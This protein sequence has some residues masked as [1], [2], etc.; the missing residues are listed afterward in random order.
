MDLY[1]VGA[2][3][4][5]ACGFVLLCAGICI[6]RY[7][8]EGRFSELRRMLSLDALCEVRPLK[9]MLSFLTSNKGSSIYRYCERVV[10]GSETGISIKVLL[11]LKMLSLLAAITLVLLIRYTN[12]EVMK[13][14]IIARSSEAFSF[15]P[16]SASEDYSYNLSLYNSVLKRVGAKALKEL[17][18]GERTDAVRKAMQELVQT[19]NPELLEER[20]RT[21]I[22]TYA[23]VNSFRLLDLQTVL[24]IMAAFW[25]PEI[26]LLLRRL[27]LGSRYKNELI[28]LENIFELLGS[29]Q[30]F[31][32]I[33]I[34]EEMTQASRLFRKHLEQ[35][36]RLFKTEKELAL[37]G[38]RQSIKNS[39]LASL[40]D[41]LR[42][43]SMT[44]KQLAL[45]ILERSRVEKEE[46]A[47]M[48]AEEDVD[49]ADVIAFI[50]IVPV[51]LELANLLMK[52]MLDMI[53]EAFKY[54]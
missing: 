47:L 49:A 12:M 54:V 29:V 30:G 19:E 21:F 25:L 16:G 17:S 33:R 14:S 4:G 24:I 18:S 9:G 34:L 3:I 26:I 5:V 53:Y 15:F 43:Y 32:T 39:R 45:Q 13:T 44:D 51:L 8:R 23:A 1:K 40:V 35:C 50:S 6:S 31:K 36:R 7:P 11:L 22:R 41:V 48:T 37:E 28:K 2:L 38:L 27:L 20:S 52:P 46:E 10:K 42:I